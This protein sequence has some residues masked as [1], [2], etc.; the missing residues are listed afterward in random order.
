M[1]NGGFFQLASRLARYT[2][3]DTYT[4]WAEKMWDW[5]STSTLIDDSDPTAWKIN[6]GA[7]VGDN[8]AVPKVKAQASTANHTS[9]AADPIFATRQLQPAK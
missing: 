5:L 3:N 6:D 4:Q 1:Q 7:G 9:G 8:C 2:A